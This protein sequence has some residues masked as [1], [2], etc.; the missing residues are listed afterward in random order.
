MSDDPD[1][2]CPYRT[3]FLIFMCIGI[4]GCSTGVYDSYN[5]LDIISKTEL[6]KTEKT[7]QN[8]QTNGK[9]NS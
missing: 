1:Y 2:A 5:N 9:R 8:K 7:K 3:A 6:T 4:F